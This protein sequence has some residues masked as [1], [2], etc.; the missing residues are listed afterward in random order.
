MDRRDN[1]ALG[2]QIFSQPSHQKRVIAIA[3][4]QDH[5]WMP[6]ADWLCIGSGQPGL[7]KG[8]RPMGR[9]TP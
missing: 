8:R 1:I 2:R 3:V 4:R 9:L 6:T 5:Q 7:R